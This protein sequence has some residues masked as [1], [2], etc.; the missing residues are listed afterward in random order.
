MSK[1]LDSFIA[2][3]VYLNLFTDTSTGDK[4]RN[5]LSQE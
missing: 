3:L 1:S 4:I 2:S 5:L